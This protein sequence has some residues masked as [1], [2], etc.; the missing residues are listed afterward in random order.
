MI[1][2]N[3]VYYSIYTKLRDKRSMILLLLYGNIKV[4]FFNKS[5]AIPAKK[6][7]AS[8]AVMTMILCILSIEFSGN[9][10]TFPTNG[11]TN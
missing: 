10:C 8:L 11:Y 1:Y 4:F 3:Q 7:N 2:I 6:T 9:I 5:W